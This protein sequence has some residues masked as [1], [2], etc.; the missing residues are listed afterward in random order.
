MDEI[1]WCDHS[2]ETSWRELLHSHDSFFILQK[3]FLWREEVGNI[4]LISVTRITVCSS[5]RTDAP[6]EA[7]QVT[8]NLLNLTING[9]FVLKRK[10]T[11]NN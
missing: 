5:K 6:K 1:L 9:S 4:K 7:R 3:I 10:A 2:N 11:L 8:N